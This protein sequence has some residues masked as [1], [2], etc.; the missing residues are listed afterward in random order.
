MRNNHPEMWEALGGE[1][2]KPRKKKKE[3]KYGCPHC[4][5]QE[6]LNRK[7]RLERYNDYKDDLR[8]LAKK[9]GF[10]M[11]VAGW[12][13]YFYIPMPKSWSKKK[14]ELMKGQLHLQKPDIDNF[15]KGFYDALSVVDEQIAQ[16]SGHGK[17]WIAED[18]PGYIEILLNQPI[19]NPFNVTF[20][21]Q[22]AI[23]LA[24]KRKWQ[25]SRS[26][27]TPPRKKPVRKIKVK[28]DKIK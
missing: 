17:F 26:K 4:L 10:E 18:E 2:W 12:A 5:S 9:A 25:R 27:F 21:D 8:G 16:L 11:P 23:K 20:I 15:E 3:I 7:K 28:D 1:N 24:P 6:N 19:Y 13:L 14:K 22:K